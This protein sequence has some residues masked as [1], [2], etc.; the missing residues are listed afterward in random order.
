MTDNALDKMEEVDQDA[1]RRRLWESGQLLALAVVLVAPSYSSALLEAFRAS[2]RRVVP[3]VLVSGG[4]RAS[5][6]SHSPAKK[7]YGQHLAHIRS[8][9]QNILG[10]LYANKWRGPRR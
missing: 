8:D 7:I 5:I 4:G 1:R 2:T 10:R 9:M 3:Y 6:G